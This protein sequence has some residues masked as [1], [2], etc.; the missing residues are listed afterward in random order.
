MVITSNPP[1]LITSNPPKL[2]TSNPPKPI[3]SNPPK[4]ITSNPPKGRY[5]VIEFKNIQIKFLDLQGYKLEDKA[6]HLVD[7]SLP[8]ILKLRITGKYFPGPIE[9]RLVEDIRNEGDIH[10]QLREYVTSKTVKE[11]SEGRTFR[12]F[13]VVIIGS[14]H[15]LIREMDKMGKWKSPSRLVTDSGLES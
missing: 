13:A 7:M 12:A 4:L 14:R 15:I 6:K 5:T 11:D 9:N 8:Q 2:I 10:K 3:T 1:K